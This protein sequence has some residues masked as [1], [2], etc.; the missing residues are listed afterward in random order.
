MR[1]FALGELGWTRARWEMSSFEEFNLAVDGY[2]RNY[3]RLHLYPMRELMFTEIAGNPY[4]KSS[5]KPTSSQDLFKLSIDG[6]KPKPEKPTEEDI[7]KAK[8]FQK[9]LLNGTKI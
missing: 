3:E 1:S 4:I 2:W 7:R 5:N 6:E 9:T 8:E